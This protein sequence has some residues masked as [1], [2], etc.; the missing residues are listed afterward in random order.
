MF[1]KIIFQTCSV[2]FKFFST[3]KQSVL[4]MKLNYCAKNVFHLYSSSHRINNQKFALVA[5]LFG[6]Q[7]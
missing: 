6:A 7:S 4:V 3:L 2:Y 5:W 1:D